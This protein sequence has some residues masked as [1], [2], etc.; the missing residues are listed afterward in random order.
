MRVCVRRKW[1]ASPFEQFHRDQTVLAATAEAK[2]RNVA[3]PNFDWPCT[4]A[5]RKRALKHRTIV[6]RQI[7]FIAP[8]R[9]SLPKHYAPQTFEAAG[10]KAR[11]RSHVENVGLETRERH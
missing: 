5:I 11:E 2:R 4:S 8:L 10:V 1:N 6:I 7:V 3:F 9:P